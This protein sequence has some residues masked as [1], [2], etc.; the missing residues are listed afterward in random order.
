MLNLNPGGGDFTPYIK[1]NAKAGRF[2][3]K[4]PDP[5]APEIEVINPRLAVD[6]DN[7]KTGWVLYQEGQAPQRL[8][9]VNG[10]RQPRPQDVG[11]AKWKEGFEV[12][13]Y[14][15]DV[16]QTI[17]DKLGLREFGGSSGSLINGILKAHALYT[18]AK[19]A[20][21]GNV[22]V[23]NVTG[24]VPVKTAKATNY[25]PVFQ[26]EKW[27]P[28]AAIPAFNGNATPPTDRA[29]QAPQPAPQP[30]PMPPAA[31][32]PAAAGAASEF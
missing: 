27:V 26:L 16:I 19:A 2:Y 11:L 23:F 4:S 13:V 12:S 9:D 17:G 32:A 30:A 29:A 8:W 31:M 22:P 7:I 20:N 6:F 1:Y 25:E 14:G 21:I 10:V 18:A 28:R 24:V 5:T 15:G 3:V